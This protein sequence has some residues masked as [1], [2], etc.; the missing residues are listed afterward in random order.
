MR[1]VK[2]LEKLRIVKVV[3]AMIHKRVFVFY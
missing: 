2:Q 1:D 3:H